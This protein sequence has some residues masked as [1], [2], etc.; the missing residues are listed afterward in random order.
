MKLTTEARAE[1]KGNVK[2]IQEKAAQIRKYAEQIKK[3]MEQIIE[4]AELVEEDA[5][6]SKHFQ[7]N[8]SDNTAWRNLPR[9]IVSCDAKI[10]EHN[11]MKSML[12]E[13]GFDS[14]IIYLSCGVWNP[15]QHLLHDL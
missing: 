6:F 15:Y 13:L 3:E 8:P 12:K 5:Q 10:N 4:F 11:N 7:M 9:A 1:L 14:E 2:V